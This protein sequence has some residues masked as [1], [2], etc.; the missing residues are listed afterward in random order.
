MSAT[1]DT[2]DFDVERFAIARKRRGLKGKELARRAGVSEVTVS[3][4]AKMRNGPKL[5]TIE[6]LAR[7]LEYPLDFFFRDRIE[8]LDVDEVSFRSMSGMRAREREAAIAAGSIGLLLS[9]W[10]EARFD[11]P[12]ADI[13]DLRNED[14]EQAAVTLRCAWK[15]GEK[16]VTRTLKLLESR[17]VRTFSL[18][19]Q[20]RRVDAFSFWRGERP[21]MFLNMMKTAEHSVFDGAH[22]LGHLVLH[23]HRSL[24]DTLTDLEQEAN[25]FAA[26]FLMPRRDVLANLPRRIDAH[27]IIRA[28]AR[29]GVSAMALARRCYTLERLTEWQYRTACIELSRMGYRSG[30]PRGIARESSVVWNKVFKALWAERM[31]KEDV[32]RELAVPLDEVE[33]L[34]FGL[35][36]PLNEVAR[37]SSGASG[38]SV[39]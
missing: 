32:A 16:P 20:T 10:V 33:S 22:E 35:L 5:E 8:T 29:W 24:A 18:S 39:V 19:E 6:A 12:P 36:K 15:L 26:A 23:R 17:G 28:K 11:L 14:P 25:T 1:R 3:R 7:A 37:P 31:T 21:F 30:E 2:A 34:V 38:L 27:A 4:I 9:E 13:P